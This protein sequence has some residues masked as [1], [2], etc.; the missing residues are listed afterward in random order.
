MMTPMHTD[1][2]KYSTPTPATSHERQ[3]MRTCRKARRAAF[4]IFIA[5]VFSHA[6]RS[7]MKSTRPR[8]NA[9]L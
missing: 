9:V 6:H 1:L 2:M 5:E 4:F 3:A 8:A 7:P